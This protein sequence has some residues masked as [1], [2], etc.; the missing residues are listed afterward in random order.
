MGLR[1]ELTLPGAECGLRSAISATVQ[2]IDGAWEMGLVH[3]NGTQVERYP[4]ERPELRTLLEA[5]L[6]RL[7][8]TTLAPVVTHARNRERFG[9]DPG[10]LE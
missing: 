2:V 9:A 4:G 5:E 8:G 1:V 10:P 6:T 7:T 3:L